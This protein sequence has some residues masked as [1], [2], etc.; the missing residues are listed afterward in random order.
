MQTTSGL[1]KVKKEILRFAYKGRELQGVGFWVG[2]LR[3]D[4][5][6]VNGIESRLIP[7]SIMKDSDRVQDFVTSTHCLYAHTLQVI[8]SKPKETQKVDLVF[9]ECGI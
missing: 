7:L 9:L 8:I 6:E 5:L 2:N 1:L 4:P 3:D